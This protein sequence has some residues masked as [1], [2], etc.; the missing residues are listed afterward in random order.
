M[1]IT[2]DEVQ[3][4]IA[5]LVDQNQDT[6][7]ITDDDYAL[8]LSYLNMA[9]SEWAEVNDWQTLYAEYNMNVST[10]S[11]ASILLPTDFRKLASF[12]LIDG[13][14]YPQTRPQDQGQY[15]DTDKRV[16][17]V[18]NNQ[19]RFVLR[20]YGS[21]ACGASVKV[22]YYATPQ[23]LATSTDIAEIP[24]S[25]YLVKRS[26]AYLW[27]ASEDPRFPQMKGEADRILSNMI[28][29]ENVFGKGSTNDRVRTEEDLHYT[30]RIGR[31]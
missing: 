14:Q 23:S 8:R 5:A 9:L 7:D 27:E 4:R 13:T 12:P 16:E 19:D 10:A 11:N 25:D 1:R 31:D 2:V 18:G 29:F 28:E 20:V 22:P 6:A 24:N 17:V 21:L 3:S 15:L 26:V 30:F